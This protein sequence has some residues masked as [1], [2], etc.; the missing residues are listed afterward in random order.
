MEEEY[1]NLQLSMAVV[2]LA[3]TPQSKKGGKA[4]ERYAKELSS[5]LEKS[6]VPWLVD[7]KR[8]RIR[9]RLASPPQPMVIA[10]GP[11]PDMDGLEELAKSGG[12]ELEKKQ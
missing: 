9:K 4:M 11:G 5:T 7:E 6:M 2:M 8:A 10:E 3:R 12:L 1:E